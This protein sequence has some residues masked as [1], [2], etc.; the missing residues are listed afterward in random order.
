MEKLSQII[1]LKLFPIEK[2]LHLPQKLWG[3]PVR[4]AEHSA[5]TLP[6]SLKSGLLDPKKQAGSGHETV[7]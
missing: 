7:R 3:T 1:S 4:Q 2:H 5:V 6:S